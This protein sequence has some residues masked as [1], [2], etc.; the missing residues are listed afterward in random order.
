MA[1]HTERPVIEPNRVYSR[2]EVAEILNV[3]LST[4]K[5]LIAARR[6]RVSQPLGMRRV[7]IRGQH[8]LDMLAE[9]EV[10]DQDVAQGSEKAP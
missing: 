6:L 3:S 10:K 5:R 8:I 1:H 2:E 4:V 7:L 9:S